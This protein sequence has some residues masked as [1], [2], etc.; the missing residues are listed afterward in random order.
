MWLSPSFHRQIDKDN[1]SEEDNVSEEDRSTLPRG[2]PFTL[3]VAQKPS[4]VH[5][6]TIT[7]EA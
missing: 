6:S 7:D 4:L 3:V 5:V 2:Y 1:F